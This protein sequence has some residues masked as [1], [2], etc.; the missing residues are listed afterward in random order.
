M[1]LY[2]HRNHTASYSSQSPLPLVFTHKHFAEVT[3]DADDVTLTVAI[4][5]D[6]WAE[7]RRAP[8]VA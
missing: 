6:R 5:A 7:M 1:V 2:V 3:E 8:S 4:W